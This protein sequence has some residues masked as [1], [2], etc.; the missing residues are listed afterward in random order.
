[1][2]GVIDSEVEVQ[3]NKLRDLLSTVDTL[4]VTMDI[5][6]DRKTRG[7]LGLTAHFV[8]QNQLKTA[9]LAVPRFQG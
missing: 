4:S 9:V 8:S 2:H 5:W 1:M 3:E 7:Y 6:S